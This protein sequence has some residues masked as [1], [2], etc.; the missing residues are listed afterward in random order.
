MRLQ[1]ANRSSYSLSAAEHVFRRVKDDVFFQLRRVPVLSRL[2]FS[3]GN[4]ME[5]AHVRVRL[6]VL[7]AIIMTETE[8]D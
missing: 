2:C 3:D 1:P 6:L 5:L 8:Q 7:I 4:W